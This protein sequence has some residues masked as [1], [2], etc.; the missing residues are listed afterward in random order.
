MKEPKICKSCLHRKVC[1]END[2]AYTDYIE[3]E[4]AGFP[5]DDYLGWI[6]CTER[7]P[8]KFYEHGDSDYMLC[9]VKYVSERT[10]DRVYLPDV[11]YYENFSKTWNNNGVDVVAWMPIPD[12]YQEGEA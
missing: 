6:P 2:K 9:T 1:G 8:D 11:D 3:W 12:P 7:L 10:G 4:K 5:C